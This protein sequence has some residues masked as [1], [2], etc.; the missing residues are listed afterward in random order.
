MNK[1]DTLTRIFN[2]IKTKCN[3][4][5]TLHLKTDSDMFDLVFEL[6]D[7]FCLIGDTNIICMNDEK[8]SSLTIQG[9]VNILCHEFGHILDDF[10]TP[11]P[12]LFSS[13]EEVIAYEKAA[14]DIGRK[15]YA[16]YFPQATYWDNHEDIERM[17]RSFRFYCKGQAQTNELPSVFTEAFL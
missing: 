12:T 13:I 10:N 11:H 4:E 16:E 8:F 1:K 14:N 15:L 17:Q 3:L 6:A 9:L 5:V 2:E 7:W